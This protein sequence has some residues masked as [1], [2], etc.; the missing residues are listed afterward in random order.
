MCLLLSL[1]R[2]VM[3]KVLYVFRLICITYIYIII[4]I[5]SKDLVVEEIKL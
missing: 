3:E 2:H 1:F 4:C 5:I